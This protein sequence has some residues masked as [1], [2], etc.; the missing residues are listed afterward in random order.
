MRKLALPLTVAVAAG[1]AA[2][3]MNEPQSAR[4]SSFGPPA[5]ATPSKSTIAYR[6]GFGVV[7]SVSRAPSLSASAGD[8]AV[9][10]STGTVGSSGQP[11]TSSGEP[12]YRLAVRMEDGRLQVVDTDEN[13]PVGTRIELT[14]DKH[15]RRQ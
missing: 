12:M 15:I 10:S 1:L 9:R 5:A 2:C 4:T 11:V 14:E 8:S 6:P 13:Y 3:A 7:E